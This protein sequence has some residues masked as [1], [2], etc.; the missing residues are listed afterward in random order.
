MSR[1]LFNAAKEFPTQNSKRKEGRE[2]C[3]ALKLGFH[4]RYIFDIGG[5]LNSFSEEVQ[6]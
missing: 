1:E 5:L 3:F 4:L 2:F 6:P